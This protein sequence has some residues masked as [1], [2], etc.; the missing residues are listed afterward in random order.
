MYAVLLGCGNY[1]TQV[2]KEMVQSKFFSHILIG[3][4]DIGKAR[5]LATELGGNGVSLDARYVNANEPETLMKVAKGADV[6]VN[7]ISPYSKYCFAVVSAAIE[8]GVNYVDICDKIEPTRS[9][10]DQLDEPAQ[11][12][13][14]TILM[15]LGG[16]PGITNIFARYGAD[17]LD[18]VEAAHTAFVTVMSHVLPSHS[19]RDQ[20]ISIGGTVPV[21]KDG[22]YIDVPVLNNMETV[23]FVEAGVTAQIYPINHPP[24]ITLPRFIKGVRTA[25]CKGG[26]YPVAVTKFIHALVSYGLAG[27]EV[28]KIG[29][30]DGMLVDFCAALCS[31]KTVFDAMSAGV[32]KEGQWVA[33]LVRVK[34]RKA[35]KPIMLSYHYCSHKKTSTPFVVTLGARMLARGEIKTKGVI[36]PEALD[37]MLFISEFERIGPNTTWCE[38]KEAP[39][40]II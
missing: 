1:G 24:S 19:W 27:T 11:K 6:V 14:V 3:D 33:L 4:I 7:I 30:A 39:I 15:G 16:H 2:L 9:V 8:A 22:A 26:Y 29:D 36:A 5:A 34:G 23:R 31:S 32:G 13:G 18:E 12:A 28:I 21:Y 25:S 40:K 38:V 37:P 10:L 20:L 35:G 17:Q